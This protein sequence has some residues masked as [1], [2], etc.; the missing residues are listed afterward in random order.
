MRAKQ[1]LSLIVM[2][3]YL[4]GCTEWQVQP[5]TPKQLVETEQPS[6]VRVETT[7]KEKLVLHQP[8]IRDD[9]LWSLVR[10]DSTRIS[11]DEIVPVE[12]KAALPGNTA[13]LVVGIVAYLA[14]G[15]AYHNAISNSRLGS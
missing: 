7:R 4:A 9:A 8:F 6:K 12:K 15:I 13:F 3:S 1:I 11:L 2:V 10:G 5:V 14:L